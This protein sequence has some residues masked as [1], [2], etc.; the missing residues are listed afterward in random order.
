MSAPQK[1][2]KNTPAIAL[3]PDD[4]IPHGRCP[5]CDGDD[6]VAYTELTF[7]EIII[8]YQRCRRCDLVFMN[9]VPN[10]E[11]YDRLYG[12]AFWETKSAKAAAEKTQ[13]RQ[14]QLIKELQRT[15][16]L[17]AALD[18]A[19]C[20]PAPGARLLEIG[21][22]FGLIISSIA[23]HY[24]AT[25]FGVEPSEMA[26]GFAKTL[27]DVEII[28]PTIDQLGETAPGP[29]GEMDVILFSHVM[30]NVVDLNRVFAAIDRWLAPNGVVLM[31]TPNSTVQ[32]STH[33]YHPYCFSQDSL[34][35]LFGGH[36]FE[37]VSL[38]ASGRPSSALIP[39]YLTLVA[40]RRAAEKQ[41]AAN[42]PHSGLDRRF[43]HGWRQ[44]VKR[45]PLKFVDRILTGILYAPDAAAK[46]RAG[47]L[48]KAHLAEATGSGEDNG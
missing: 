15:D 29:G 38:R 7:H 6:L 26:A 35:Q 47:D 12:Q 40:K 14:K 32:N 27:G 11:W 43:G 17:C 48:A 28:A 21:C 19:G 10:Q 31:E 18:A 30:E 1:E 8:P 36:G 34:R 23:E 37:I 3:T 20:S 16:K 45:T 25:P 2:Q 9:P 33:I 22:A 42:G 39:R 4:V 13:A 46:Q 24:Q 5:V 44:T 41:P